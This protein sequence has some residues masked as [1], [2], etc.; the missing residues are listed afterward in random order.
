MRRHPRDTNAL[1]KLV[2]LLDMDWLC[3]LIDEA[4]PKPNRPKAYRKS[5]GEL[6]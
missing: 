4:Q 6:L 3:D 1:A 5:K 2:V